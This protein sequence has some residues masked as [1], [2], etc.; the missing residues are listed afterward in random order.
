M[1]LCDARP[2]AH[3]VRVLVCLLAYIASYMHTC[4]AYVPAYTH[5]RAQGKHAVKTTLWHV[6]RAAAPAACRQLTFKRAREQGLGV[7]PVVRWSKLSR[8]S[9]LFFCRFGTPHNLH[10][11]EG[12]VSEARER[13]MEGERALARAAMQAGFRAATPWSSACLRPKRAST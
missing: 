9:S 2:A 11:S 10:T 4:T 3:V 13:V 8:Q 1:Y 7:R 5:A 6:A 12:P